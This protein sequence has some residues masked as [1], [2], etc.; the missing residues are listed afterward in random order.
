MYQRVLLCRYFKRIL[1]SWHNASHRHCHQMMLYHTFRTIYLNI[2]TFFVVNSK[3]GAVLFERVTLWILEAG[4]WVIETALSALLMATLSGQTRGENSFLRSAASTNRNLESGRRS[5]AKTQQINSPPSSGYLAGEG[6]VMPRMCLTF[7]TFDESWKPCVWHRT[8]G[9]T[10]EEPTAV[11]L[12][13]KR[14]SR[15]RVH[16]C[17]LQDMWRFS[18]CLRQP[19]LRP[20]WWA[21]AGEGGRK[22]QQTKHKE[23]FFISSY[24]P[25]CHICFLSVRPSANF[26]P[27]I[28]L[29]F[30]TFCQETENV[31]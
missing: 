14:Q 30:Y 7:K 17:L 22:P 4:G 23:T 27:V 8:A 18:S 13:R 20:G 25:C 1:Q 12:P 9:A 11:T 5:G 10:L 6:E 24:D 15:V 31:C 19:S 16:D 26:C 21:R 28:F 3:I 29:S 2:T